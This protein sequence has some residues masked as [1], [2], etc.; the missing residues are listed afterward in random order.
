MEIHFSDHHA[1]CA[2]PASLGQLNQALAEIGLA[3]GQAVIVLVGGYIPE[4][5][6]EVT[7]RAIEVIAAFAE[8]NPA[9]IICG[10]TTVGI[11]GSIGQIR[12]ALGYKFPLLGITLENRATW[13][14]GPRGK[15]FLWW[16]KER[17]P[18]SP[19]YSHFLLVPGDQFG[20]DS[21]WLV[22]AATCLS[23]GVRSVTVL[24]NGGGVAR[25]DVSLSL[26][27]HRPVVILAGTGRLAD[28]LVG[29]PG[30]TPLAT[31][32]QAGDGKALRDELQRQV[33]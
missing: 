7:Q 29:Q 16:G 15:K 17:W 8:E 33:G 26:D 25:K 5:H 21:P 30:K 3:D 18:L 32:V 10:G 6:E 27:N 4:G 24:A 13:P 14:N 31:I 28:E 23:Q 20:E 19:G 9:A 12:A 22:E 11:M 1:L 2:F